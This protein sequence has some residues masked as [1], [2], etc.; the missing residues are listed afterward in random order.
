MKCACASCNCTVDMSSAIRRKNLVYCSEQCA[1]RDCTPEVCRC[2]HD[3]CG[4]GD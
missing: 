2:E 4:S 1:R 3:H